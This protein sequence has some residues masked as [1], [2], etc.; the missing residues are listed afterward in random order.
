M[1]QNHKNI[2]IIKT[3]G[4]TLEFVANPEDLAIII[5][6]IEQAI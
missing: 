5:E 4:D 2:P 3:N 1:K 6:K